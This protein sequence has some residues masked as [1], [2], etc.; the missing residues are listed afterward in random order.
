M[1]QSI[2][3]PHTLASVDNLVNNFSQTIHQPQSHKVM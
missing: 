2:Q 1:I 3:Y